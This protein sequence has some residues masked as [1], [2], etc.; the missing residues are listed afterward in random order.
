MTYLQ[1][2]ISD[3]EKEA[4]RQV[5]DDMGLSLSA[6]VKIFLRKTV[7]EQKLPFEI[8]AK[9][10]K[11]LSVKTKEKTKKGKSKAFVSKKKEVQM[12]SESRFTNFASREIE[13]D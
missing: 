8:S 11:P 7:Q 13:S 2:R 10:N 9:L 12:P 6:A 3:E 4:A 5:L 1:V